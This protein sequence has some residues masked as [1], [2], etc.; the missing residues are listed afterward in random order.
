MRQ[1]IITM[2]TLLLILSLFLV[3]TDQQE[4]SEHGVSS[5]PN[6]AIV[7][8]VGLQWFV[9]DDQQGDSAP[10]LDSRTSYP[11]LPPAPF[12][13][14]H[15]LRSPLQPLLVGYSIRGPPSVLA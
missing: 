2:K 15:S 14:P 10:A 1:A 6:T 12:A 8:H 7:F 5:D 9:D 3:A 11:L 13:V 4:V